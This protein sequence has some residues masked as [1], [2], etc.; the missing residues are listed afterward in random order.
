MI[1]AKCFPTNPNSIE[2]TISITMSLG[3]WQRLVERIDSSYPGW[4][5]IAIIQRAVRK[6]ALEYSEV[7]EDEN[8]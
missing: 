8:S 4:P 5:V 6:A 1:K 7:L 2:L 3:E